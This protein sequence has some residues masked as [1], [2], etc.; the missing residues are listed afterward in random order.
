MSPSRVAETLAHGLAADPIFCD[1]L[2]NLH[3][4]LEREVDLD[5]LSRSGGPAPLAKCRWRMRSSR[6]CRRWGARAH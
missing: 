3:L 1:L 5:R 4:H 6:R 2:A